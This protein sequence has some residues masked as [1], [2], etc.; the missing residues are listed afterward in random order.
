MTK[1]RHSPGQALSTVSATRPVPGGRTARRSV[2]TSE[3]IGKG[4]HKGQAL[5]QPR[6]SLGPHKGQ[7]PKRPSGS[8]SGRSEHWN[9]NTLTSLA[10]SAKAPPFQSLL[11]ERRPDTAEPRPPKTVAERCQ[12]RASLGGEHPTP[13]RTARKLLLSRAYSAS[14]GLTPR[15]PPK[16]V[17]ERC[18]AGASLGGEHPTPS[19]KARKLIVPR[20]Y[21][22][23][24]GLTPRSPGSFA[25][26]SHLPSSPN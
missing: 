11:S 5:K 10:H 7:A 15:S 6:R 4:P 21:S 24:G 20:A 26:R 16:T 13:S 9:V 3:V 23:S 18:R 12:A 2:P 14:G 8:G 22:A 19:R 17:A 25:N 1:K